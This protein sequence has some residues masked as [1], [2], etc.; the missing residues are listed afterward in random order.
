LRVH[1]ELV[2]MSIMMI[3]MP[4]VIV[5][6]IVSISVVIIVPPSI[7]LVFFFTE[8]IGFVPSSFDEYFES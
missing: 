3:V 1:E 4:V 6:R 2:V 7:E 5:M 8:T